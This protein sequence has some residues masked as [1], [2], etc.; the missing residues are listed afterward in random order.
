MDHNH[1]LARSKLVGHLIKFKF[2]NVS[3]TYRLR[4]IMQDMWEDY[5]VNISY[6]KSWWSKE[7]DLVQGRLESLLA[8]CML[9]GKL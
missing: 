4:D 5:G 8:S 3:R 7:E 2:A 6:T 9:M 1:C